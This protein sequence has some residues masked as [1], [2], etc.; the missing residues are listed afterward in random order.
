[1]KKFKE[2]ETCLECSAKKLIYV[3]EVFYFA[4]KAVVHPSAPLFDANAD[5]GQ[6]AL[7]P[8]C[9]RAL[10]RIFMMNDLDKVRNPLQYANGDSVWWC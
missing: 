4:L 9:V 8:L 3:G 7:K 1:M 2:I 6:G 5:N 10:K